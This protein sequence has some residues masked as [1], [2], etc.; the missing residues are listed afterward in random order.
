[1]CQQSPCFSATRSGALQALREASYQSDKTPLGC[2]SPT[3]PSPPHPH[4]WQLPWGRLGR[5]MKCW[6]L[7]IVRVIPVIFQASPK[8]FPLLGLWEGPNRNNRH[9]PWPWGYSALISN[10]NR[11]FGIFFFFLK[12][13]HQFGKQAASWWSSPNIHHPHSDHTLPPWKSQNACQELC[14]ASYAP[15]QTASR[16]VWWLWRPL[17]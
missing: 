7:G 13:K 10:R 8:S 14:H 6:C 1:M 16:R 9:F 4:L 2:P 15:L 12:T 17:L 11:S 5:Q 3:K